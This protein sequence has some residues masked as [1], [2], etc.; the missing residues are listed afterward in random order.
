MSYKLRYIIFFI[1]DSCIVLSAIFMSYWLLHPTLNVYS[2]KVIVLS[3]ITLLI[4]H[5]IAA[6]FFKLYTRVWSVAS[7]RELLTIAY[8]VTISVGTASMLQQFIN[9]DIYFRVLAVTWMLH[10]IMIGGSR[11][12]LRLLNDKESFKNPHDIKRVLIVGAGQGGSMLAKT[13]KIEAKKISRQLD[14]LMMMSIK[15]I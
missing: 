13:F 10:I 8:A 11:F 3:A 5:H 7:V 6:Y 9:N 14:L 4:S 2:N 15:S 1:M 12:L